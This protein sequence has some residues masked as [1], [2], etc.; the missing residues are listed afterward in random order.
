[1][2]YFFIITEPSHRM[3]FGERTHGRPW[4]MRK[5][6]RGAVIHD[7]FRRGI[8]MKRIVLVTC[9]ALFALCASAQTYIDFHQ[10]PVATAPTPMP[11]NYPA[12]FNLYWENFY[13]V[14]PGVWH[15]AGP[16]F[17]VD[18]ATRHNSVAF[19]GGPFCTIAATCNGTIK[20]QSV[21]A[22]PTVPG[23]TPVSISLTSGWVANKLKVTAYNNSQFVGSLVWQLT[24]EPKTFPFPATW[25][26]V[27]Q[28][29]FTPS[30]IPPNATNPQ[31]GSVVVY[32]FILV[33]H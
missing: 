6:R 24:T 1:M 9:F 3:R 18:P 17:W 16:G 28:L 30:S 8:V 20:L 11:D 19:F 27:T 29:V 4:V 31:A 2:P 14:S 13:Y 21:G 5:Y 33:R 22:T 26:N 25:K 10:M 7:P 15:D 12:G 23:F 32:S